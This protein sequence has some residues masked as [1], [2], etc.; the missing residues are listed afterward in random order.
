MRDP[1]LAWRSC[2]GISA[3]RSR[4]SLRSR[5]RRPVAVAIDP[6][7]TRA[8]ADPEAPYELIDRIADRVLWLAPA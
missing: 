7:V 3:S 8:V 6:E 4:R 1:P 2:P 5:V